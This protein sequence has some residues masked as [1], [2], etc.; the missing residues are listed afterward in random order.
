MSCQAYYTDSV[1]SSEIACSRDG[2]GH[3]IKRLAR[4]KISRACQKALIGLSACPIA[5]IGR[6]F[7]T[8]EPRR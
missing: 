2:P 6:I 4:L 8:P 7:Q 5:I 3:V 1:M